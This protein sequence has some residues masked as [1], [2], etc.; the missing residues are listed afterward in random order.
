MYSKINSKKLLHFILIIIGVNTLV[1]C[2]PED[3]FVNNGLSEPIDASFTIAPSEDSANRF[4]LTVTSK[5]LIASKWD[6][7]TGEGAYSG[8]NNEEIF[9][10]DAGTYSISH[11]AI[12]KG[13]ESETVTQELTVAESDPVAGNLVQGGKFLNSE[14]YAKW[15]SLD[16]STSADWNFNPGSATINSTG[17][18]AQEAIYQEIEIVK[19]KEYSIDMFVESTGTFN[20]TWFEV[21]AGTTPPVLGQEYTDNRIMGLSTWD[22]CA[23]SAFSGK[24]S[25]VGCVVNANTSTINNTVSFDASGTIYLVI[26]CGGN[27]FDPA[28]ITMTNVEFRG[29]N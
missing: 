19:D 17:G 5:N 23:T 27:T 3:S 10:P 4:L 21:Y 6:L 25:S 15:T 18:W 8:N 13:G 26:R 20:E 12:G 29:K 1:S 24:L 28:G 11:I 9:L 22:G 14:D 2:Q 16:L 7:G